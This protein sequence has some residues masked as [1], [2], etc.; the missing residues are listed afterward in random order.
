MD[1]VHKIRWRREDNIPAWWIIHH[2]SCMKC[3]LFAIIQKLWCTCLMFCHFHDHELTFTKEF[4][5]SLCVRHTSTSRMKHK[6]INLLSLS[7]DIVHM[8]VVLLSGHRVYEQWIIRRRKNNHTGSRWILPNHHLLLQINYFFR[9]GC[10][11]GIHKSSLR[12]Y[13]VVNNFF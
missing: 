4:F 2:Q 13:G 7:D 11:G 3:K 1:T 12:F 9:G 5:T 8:C 10:A 6:R